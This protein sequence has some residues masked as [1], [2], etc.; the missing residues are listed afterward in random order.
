MPYN[1]AKLMIYIFDSD[2]Y[3]FFSLMIFRFCMLQI[4]IICVR[5]NPYTSDHP[6]EAEFLPMF[7]NKTICCYSISFTKNAAAFLRIGFPFQVLPSLSGDDE[8]PP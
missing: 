6:P 3:S 7:F 1:T 2:T 8:V 5:A 4:L